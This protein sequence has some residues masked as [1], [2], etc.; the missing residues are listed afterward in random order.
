MEPKRHLLSRMAKLLAA[1]VALYA[2]SLALTAAIGVAALVTVAG[3]IASL[4]SQAGSSDLSTIWRSLSGLQQIEGMAG[5]LL[6]TLA[7]IFLGARAIARISA[8]RLLGHPVRYAGVVADMA[9]FVP[10]ALAYSFMI[11]LP[12]CIAATFLWLPS[13]LVLAL[14]SLVIPAGLVEAGSMFTALR[15]G[16]R[17]VDKVYWRCCILVLATAVLLV[18]IVVLRQMAF[19]NLHHEPHPILLAVIVIYLPGLPLIL[20]S[21]ICFTLLYFEARSAEAEPA[22]P[23]I[24]A[25]A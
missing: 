18:L 19:A 7:P 20:V 2:G 10:T 22:Q 21:N 24:A 25:R 1:D 11:G 16:V 6:A 13:V 8:A 12:T 14:F 5:I 23:N 9:L 15:R 3:W 4:G 17:L